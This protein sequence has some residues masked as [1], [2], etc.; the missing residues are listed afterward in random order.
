MRIPS[1]GLLICA[2]FVG[3]SAL[4]AAPVSASELPS[5]SA[6]YAV[7]LLPRSV[8][9]TPAGDRIVVANEDSDSASVVRVGVGVESTVALSGAEPTQVRITP[10]GTQAYVS[11]FMTSVNVID[12]GPNT[13]AGTLTGFVRPGASA[14]TGDS[15]KVLIPD[16]GFGVSG[17]VDKVFSFNTATRAPITDYTASLPGNLVMSPDGITAYASAAVGS[18]VTLINTATNMVRTATTTTACTVGIFSP[19]GAT[20]YSACYV[21]DRVAVIDVATATVTANVSVPDDIIDL[22]LSPDGRLV[23]AISTTSNVLSVISTQTNTVVS[24]MS[25]GATPRGVAVSQDGSYVLITTQSGSLLVLNSDGSSIL[26]T[27]SLGGTPSA[28]VVAQRG[29]FA[30]ITLSDTNELVVVSLPPR[31]ASGDQVPVAAL[32]QYAPAPGEDCGANP[33]SDVDFP[34]L[35]GRRDSGWS[36]SWAYWPNGGLGGPVCTR[37]PYY[38]SGQTWEVR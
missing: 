33:P 28:M 16:G 37:Q 3:T 36:L 14:F 24:S 23:F 38:T 35:V 26:T 12:V 27:L 15:S 34:A 30:A 32:Q 8:A 11:N 10:D 2:T 20:V 1:V 21:D 4:A 18:T 19:S 7:G 13:V 29:N 25:L 5:I 6:R 17:W 22:A 31:A 9:I